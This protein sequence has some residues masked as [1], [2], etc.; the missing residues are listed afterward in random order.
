MK[1]QI[2]VCKVQQQVKELIQEEQSWAVRVIEVLLDISTA[3][4]KQIWQKVV[5]EAVNQ[6]S[7][8]RFRNFF[9]LDILQDDQNLVSEHDVIC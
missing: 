4:L 8:E 2:S 5:V 1:K 7:Y 9:T 3:D 6:N